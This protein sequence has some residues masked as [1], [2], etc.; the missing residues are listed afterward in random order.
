[1]IDLLSWI[2]RAIFF[3]ITRPKSRCRASC[4]VL[5]AGLEAQ[6]TGLLHKQVLPAASAPL[7]RKARR[8]RI[9][10]NPIRRFAAR[11][12]WVQ[13]SSIRRRAR[14]E[15]PS[16]LGDCRKAPTGIVVALRGEIAPPITGSDAHGA[17]Y[18]SGDAL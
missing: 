18:E 5:R 15:K 1:M 17:V 7:S 9:V 16:S 14:L 12:R 8:W 2:D 11:L 6:V 3:F 10:L 13:W 4:W